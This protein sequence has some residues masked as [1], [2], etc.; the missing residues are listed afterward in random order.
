MQNGIRIK[1]KYRIP[2]KV[3]IMLLSIASLYFLYPLYYL[4]NILNTRLPPQAQLP[5]SLPVKS[6][7]APQAQLPL[8][9][10]VK[11]SVAPL[12]VMIGMATHDRPRYVRLALQALKESNHNGDVMIFDDASTEMTESELNQW[13]PPL[14]KIERLSPKRG[15]D[16]MARHIM[17]VFITRY[18][19]DVLLL[20]DSDM[21]VSSTWWKSISKALEHQQDE[22]SII[23]LHRS[24]APTHRSDKCDALLCDM[25]SMGNA[26]SVW[27]RSVAV[28]MLQEMHA[29]EGGFDWGWSE[30]CT[31]N[32]VPMRALRMS[33]VLHIGM[34]GSWSHE[35]SQEKSVGFPFETLSTAVRAQARSFLWGEPPMQKRFTETPK[36]PKAYPKHTL[37]QDKIL[38]VIP[39]Y[40]R[41]WSLQLVIDSIMSFDDS[42]SILIS[43]DADSTSVDSMLEGFKVRNKNLKILSH[44]WSCFRYPD[45][46][47]A[48]DESLNVNYKGDTYG[49]PRSSWAT[50]LKHHWW[51]MM[52][53]AW[54]QKHKHICMLEDDVVIHPQ[55]PLWLEGL[56]TDFKNVKLTPDEIAVP[57]CMSESEWMQVDPMS[58]CTHDDYNWDQTI[59]WMREH[60]KASVN[61][62][63]V[64]HKGLSLHV[65][66]CG[67]WDAG[68]RARTCTDSQ[69]DAI[70]QR[71]VEWRGTPIDTK[72]VKRKW[73]TAHSRP[74]GGWG[75]PKDW[76][77]CLD[78]SDSSSRPTDDVIIR[79]SDLFSTIDYNVA[80][81]PGPWKQG[82]DY[83][84]DKTLFPDGITVHVV[85]H[86]H[87]DPG[88]IK[89]YH[90]YYSTQ[91]KHILDAVVDSLVEDS[92]RTFIWAEI[93]YFSL[94]WGE[95][96]E[97]Q[98]HHVHTLVNEKR[99]EFVTGGW[100][101]ND[102]ACVTA[103]ATR[104]QLEE[105]RKWLKE[106][107]GV[108]PRYGWAIDPFGH[109]A[110]QAQILKEMG[111]SG[112]LIQRVHYA[113]KK[114]LAEK[115]SLEFQWKTPAGDIFTHMMPFY[116]Y[117]GPHTCGPDPS[118]CCQFD[119]ARI[120][121]GYGGCP[122]HKPS[123]EITDHNVAERSRTWVDQVRKKA[124]LYR[125]GHVLVPVGDDFRYQ[126][127]DESR[128]QFLNYQKMFDWI[129]SNMKNVRVG[130]STL[131]G[132][133]DSVVGTTSVPRLTGSFFP[134]SDRVQDYWTGYFNSRIFYKGYD[135]KLEALIAAAETLCHGTPD[136][137][138]AKRALSLFQH[139]DGITGTAKSY[140]VQDYYAT[141]RSAVHTL[142]TLLASSVCLNVNNSVSVN[143]LLTQRTPTHSPGE[144]KPW[145]ED[146]CVKQ[147][148][149]GWG[150]SEEVTF[151]ERGHI[152]SISGV[153]VQESFIWMANT[154][155]D[156]KAGAYLMSVT[157]H[158]DVLQ[159]RTQRV[160]KTSL[161]TD[162]VTAF[163]MVTRT[164]R[165]Y[166][167]GTIELICDIDIHSRN[168]GELWAVYKP[169]GAEMDDLSL[170]S[171]VHGLTWECHREMRSA[172]LQSKFYP[173]P[174]MS[175]LTLSKQK[176]ITWAG[177]QPTG[178]GLHNDAIIFMLD[179]KGNRDDERGLGQG[180]TDSKPVRMRWAMFVEVS[181]RDNDLP[182]DQSLEM[183]NWML[184]PSME[185]NGNDASRGY[186]T[187]S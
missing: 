160:C 6:S 118:I 181:N 108:T 25:P 186:E 175:W 87:N 128:K 129:T 29:R 86:S 137:T 140:V 100:V 159:P 3:L 50:C 59:A 9:L 53:Q 74:N 132:Y 21:V 69:I 48:N 7:V 13:A 78:V 94:W 151:D 167:D 36:L 153:Q 139:H 44:P 19:H 135:R 117:D 71:V 150:K 39:V 68:G 147:E 109:S 122:W 156:G 49:H 60:G 18:E 138:S 73:L 30:W 27:R 14:S 28:K 1:Y 23:S 105:G 26:G 41:S 136:L 148:G 33:A 64:P 187:T 8:P 12:T 126:S 155:G 79:T 51:W 17:E 121:G 38:W 114:Q 162:K 85:P 2:I 171:D 56:R 61:D 52:K 96:T 115:R 67:G 184:N 152:T 22:Y 15:P 54:R 47:P 81:N 133:F 101:M 179:R 99:L 170:C 166:N 113:V 112:M 102:E 164:T 144:I 4:H 5:L 157:S 124:M 93:S 90:D 92:K 45:R 65:G 42:A 32:S 165:V 57:W 20:L 106:T 55:A 35:S 10:P 141:M 76:Q 182:T 158:E 40:K 70:R 98:R 154:P 178:V 83:E 146:R 143:P 134:Y 103:R 176:R 97:L 62:V 37:K 163:D 120:G 16:A 123:V 130:F 88:W 116:S 180:V 66:D 80:D 177:A 183:R 131:S 34:Y 84:Y 46:F 58:F 77:H 75:H 119:F 95:S 82:W 43:K 127:M 173:M 31:R 185:L 104:W 142:E 145:M 11:S 63:I 111:Y 172:P 149:A 72:A 89:T 91:T 161:Y 107:L 168:N 110:G 125:S 174:T 24:A 169:T